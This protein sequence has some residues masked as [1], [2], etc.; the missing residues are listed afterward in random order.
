MQENLWLLLFA[1]FLVFLNGFFVAAEFAIVKLRGTQADTMASRYGAPGR[2]LKNVRE[3]LD[4]YLSACQLGITLASL[5]LGWVGE[6]AFARLLEPL[7]AELFGIESQATVHAIGFA[8]AFS[9]ISFLH[10]VL[11]ELAPKSMAIRRPDI[12]GLWTATPLYLFYWIMYPFIWLLNGSALL[13]LRVMGFDLEKESENAHSS[14]EL[15]QI[16]AASHHHGELNKQEADILARSLEFSELI[17][18]DL[19]RPVSEMESLNLQ[20]SAECNLKILLDHH[21]SRYPVHDG[22]RD[23]LIG[24][25]HIKDLFALMQV[26][27]NVL[28]LRPCLRDLVRVNVNMPSFKLLRRFRE[29][30]SHFAIVDDESGNIAGFVTLDML[31]QTLVGRMQ[32]EFHGGGRDWRPLRDGS[33]L[34]NG[35]LSIY[36]LEKRLGIDIVTDEAN[37]VGGLL[38]VELGR[39]PEQGERVAFDQFDIDVLK[40]EGP[41]IARLKIVPKPATAD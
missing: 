6:P 18:G 35:T 39:L 5:G 8:I 23:H 2:I 33:L 40:M 27:G 11:G 37:S 17:V 20:D 38:M 13:L 16:L 28:D 1:L 41:K 3:H 26:N 34:G 32:D 22:S 30:A 29:G 25:V 24:L 10:I 4:A 7:L 36:S 9:I 21:Y 14:E 12:M 31:L 19:M 15:K